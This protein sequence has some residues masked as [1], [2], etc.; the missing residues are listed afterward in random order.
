MYA[1][2]AMFAVITLG[3]IAL[4]IFF[5]KNTSAKQKQKKVEI[6]IILIS[7]I[8]FFDWSRRYKKH[9]DRINKRK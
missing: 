8:L 3:C 2:F 5:P 6:A 7:I 4:I 1:V 9:I